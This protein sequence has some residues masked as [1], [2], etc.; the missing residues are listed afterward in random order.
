MEPFCRFLGFFFCNSFLKQSPTATLFCCEAPEMFC[1]SQTFHLTFYQHEGEE[2]MTE[3]SFLGQIFPLMEWV[4]VNPP[5]DTLS[6]WMC[7]AN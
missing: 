4:F 3:F 1:W 2:L 6:R 5:T 7:Y